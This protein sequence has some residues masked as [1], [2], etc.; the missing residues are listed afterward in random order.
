VVQLI[1]FVDIKCDG[2][3]PFHNSGHF[4]NPEAK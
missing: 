4:T 3:D 1:Q 2:T